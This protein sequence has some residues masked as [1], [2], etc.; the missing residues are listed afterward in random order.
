VSNDFKPTGCI[1]WDLGF[2]LTLSHR[3]QPVG[4]DHLP[5]RT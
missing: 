4:L 5:I 2:S 3:M 1:R